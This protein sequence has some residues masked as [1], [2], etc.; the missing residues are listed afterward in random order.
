MWKSL[1]KDVAELGIYTLYLLDIDIKVGAH[2]PTN[3]AV[4]WELSGAP[5]G[6]IPIQIPIDKI[7]DKSDAQNSKFDLFIFNN[8]YDIKVYTV[9]L[10][11]MI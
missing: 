8:K 10:Y 5:R 6:K 11:P 2:N 1:L 3:I 7:T 9:N 4:I